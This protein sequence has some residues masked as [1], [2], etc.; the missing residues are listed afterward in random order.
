MDKKGMFR[1]SVFGGYNKDDVMDYITKIEA[2][3][4][5]IKVLHNKEIENLKN[6]RK[7]YEQLKEEYARASEQAEVYENEKN[8]SAG[9][10]EELKQE[11]DRLFR[12]VNRLREE[13]E[14]LEG[15]AADGATMSD[16]PA[17]GS[18][19][20]V[21]RLNNLSNNNE[22]LKQENERLRRRIEELER[23][24]GKG[25]SSSRIHRFERP[26]TPRVTVLAKDGTVIAG[27]ENG[28]VVDDSTAS[29]AQNGN[30]NV[31]NDTA[32]MKN[33][34]SSNQ[35][36]EL[37]SMSYS[38][39]E[40]II[41]KLLEDARYNAEQIINDA[42]MERKAILKKTLIESRELRR[43]V[44]ERVEN[45]L[46]NK[47]VKMS[48]MKHLIEKYMKDMKLLQNNLA[49]VYNGMDHLVDDMPVRI[50]GYWKETGDESEE[51][52]VD[53]KLIDNIAKE[54]LEE[55]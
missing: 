3:N 5:Q 48:A 11:N 44:C 18:E 36:V 52:V 9:K 47:G 40:D 19:E 29:S 2:E 22:A 25:S 50:D 21:E 10:I 46:E 13:N 31:N 8:R 55:D 24:K 16:V 4:E 14:R 33:M 23:N 20:L 37:N 34:V 12:E 53:S 42:K 27:Y 7:E 32:D 6:D 39:T 38:G 54:L 1:G 51:Y 28:Q 35:T 15:L 45:D 41:R 30:S 26:R 49:D 43:S 17:A